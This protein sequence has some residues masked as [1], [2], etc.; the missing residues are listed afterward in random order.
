[1]RDLTTIPY[2]GA[3]PAQSLYNPG[4][5][6]VKEHIKDNP[7]TRV[8]GDVKKEKGYL[9]PIYGAILLGASYLTNNFLTNN[10]RLNNFIENIDQKP[11]LKNADAAIKRGW[12]TVTDNSFLNTLA[13]PFKYFKNHW[14]DVQPKMAMAKSQSRALVGQMM[15]SYITM[16][17]NV[18]KKAGDTTTLNK[19]SSLEKEFKDGLPWHKAY[20]KLKGFFNNR[21][22]DKLINIDSQIRTA[23]GIKNGVVPAGTVFSKTLRGLYT[24]FNNYFNLHFLKSGSGFTRIMGPAMS[25]FAALALGNTI[26]ATT[27]AERGDKLSTFME[28]FFG[29][30]VPF[31]VFNKTFQFIYGPLGGLKKLKGKLGWPLKKVGEFLSVGLQGNPGK[32]KRFAGGSIRLVGFAILSTIVGSL[33]TRFSHKI[34]GKPQKTIEA[35]QKE[36]MEAEKG[37][38]ETNKPPESNINNTPAPPLVTQYINNKKTP[39]PT[40]ASGLLPTQ[41][42]AKASYYAEPTPISNNSPETVARLN[43]VL[44]KIDKAT[45]GYGI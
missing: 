39:A 20:E 17:L 26:K 7:A 34:F 10:D 3:I 29:D 22:P 19:L 5:I 12:G 24:Q 21:L 27:E 44:N 9:G 4:A 41:Q 45:A 40:G 15:E 43:N 32:F 18:T 38:Q 35:E 2:Y 14:N 36:K 13:K 30:V 6:P 23:S 33:A 8:V 1:M 37:K 31:A 11:S 16:A 25:L 42:Q 28:G